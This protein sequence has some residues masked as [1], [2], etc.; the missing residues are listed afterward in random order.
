MSHLEGLAGFIGTSPTPWHASLN[1]AAMLD[2][3][4]FSAVD[5][6]SELSGAPGR[7]YIVRDGALVAWNGIPGSGGQPMRMIGAHT[8]SPGLRVRPRPDRQRAGA[9]Q[10]VV[11]VYG[12]ALVNSWLDRDLTLAGRVVLAG[13]GRDDGGAR[14]PYHVELVHPPGPLARVPQ[15]AIHLDRETHTEG[16]RLNPQLHLTPMWGLE[17]GSLDGLVRYLCD[18]TG[19]GS[20]EEVLGWDLC[21]VDTQ[22]PEVL[23]AERE[24][25]AS[26]RLDDLACAYGAVVALGESAEGSVVVLSDHEEVGSSSTTGA[27]GTWFISVLE[28]LAAGAGIER[29]E[30]L[31]SISGS[32]FL[33]ADMAHATH[34]NYPERHEDNHWVQMGAGP[35]IKYNSNQRYATDALGAAAFRSACTDAGV[36]VQEYSHRGD[37][38]CGSTI[39][40]IIAAGLAVRTVDVGMP[41]LSMHSIRE[42]M[43][44]A[45]VNHMVDSFRA[46]FASGT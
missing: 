31:R 32:L 16:L 33:S 18:L 25:F 9:R 38:A 8:D 3:F 37:I 42:L 43:A 5:P 44:V 20:P 23:G 22:A 26:P 45:D 19:A 4:G 13:A 46:W 11:E 17:S 39:G 15:L 34:P 41:Q 21:L 6:S 7:G 40:P 35:V 27:D 28:R 14:D 29:A 1:G 2:R 30:L 12:G 10:L 36:P 24:L